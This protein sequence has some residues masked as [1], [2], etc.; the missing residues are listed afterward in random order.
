MDRQAVA[1][2][3][4]RIEQDGGDV[5]GYLRARGCVS[6][7]GTWYRLQKE[8]L[9]RRGPQITDGKEKNNMPRKA[10]YTD[11]QRDEAI[12]IALNGG[13]PIPYLEET[14]G[15]EEGWLGWASI[16]KWAKRSKPEIYAK[17]PARLPTKNDYGRKK[18][19]VSARPV[20]ETAKPAEGKPE[21]VLAAEP[22]KTPATGP[23]TFKG[24]PVTAIVDPDFGEF[25]RKGDW[26]DWET[27]DGAVI[28]FTIVEWRKLF[29]EAGPEIFGAIG[30]DL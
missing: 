30:A 27:N 28:S 1:R 10:R 20:K 6:P 16:K 9:H 5:L 29:K 26:I 19:T 8:E 25:H 18:R 23:L 4:E 12:R 3:C 7:W 13:T 15:Y 17:L 21:E 11:A 14:V 24:K 22:E 2:E